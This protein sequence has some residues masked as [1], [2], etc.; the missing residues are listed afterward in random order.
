MIKT[1]W[2]QY[3]PFNK[4]C[5]V[6]TDTL[7]LVGCTPLAMSQLMR[8]WEWPINGIGLNTDSW[9]ET[10]LETIDFSTAIYDYNNMARFADSSSSA[11]IQNAV[12]T[13][14]YHAGVAL[15]VSYGIRATSGD[16]KY[17]PNIISTHFNYTSQ[18]KSKAMEYTD[19]SFWI[20]SLKTTMISG[21]PVLYSAKWDTE[22]TSWHTWIVDGYKT[23]EDQFHF[24]MGWWSESIC[25]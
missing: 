12:S 14:S 13:L 21:T 22:D 9:P 17:I 6:I 23:L 8:K 25:L 3:Y 2:N 4:K 10:S 19:L 24:N 16:D 11:A 7:S 18:L 1:E 20:D 5:P 15:N